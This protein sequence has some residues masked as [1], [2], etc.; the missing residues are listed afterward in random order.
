M[1]PDYDDNEEIYR[2][3]TFTKELMTDLEWRAEWLAMMRHKAKLADNPEVH[4]QLRSQFEAELDD[5]VRQ[6]IGDDSQGF[7]LLKPRIV[8]R[9]LRDAADGRAVLNR[10]PACARVVKTPH[11]RQCLWCGHDW[12]ERT[13]PSP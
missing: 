10:C 2:Y 5:D 4:A 3:V 12:H 7:S 8:E 11:A 9:F 13:S 1:E 6:M